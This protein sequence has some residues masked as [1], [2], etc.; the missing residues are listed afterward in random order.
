MI[1]P[2]NSSLTTI[3]QLNILVDID[4]NDHKLRDITKLFLNA[5]TDWP[6]F[7]QTNISDFTKE[8]KLYF[9]TPLT[10]EKIS[11]K[12]FDTSGGD[13]WRQEA[14]SSISEMLDLSE[15]F[16]THSDFDKTIQNILS[17]YEQEL[18]NID[19]VADLKYLTNEQGGRMTPAF[20]GYR[21]QVK[22]KFAEMQT[23]G[24]QKFLDKEMVFPGDTVRAAIKIIS[25][26]YFAHSLTEGMNFEF[27]EGPNI[28]GT[29]IIKSILNDSL[30][31]AS[32]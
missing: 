30:Q 7:N 17:Y 1:L 16:Y 3:D 9:G 31:K 21:P 32:R 12:Q 18:Q 4:K 11:N 19:F 2:N 6:T 27:R 29:G 22:F 23:S 25:V 5:A 20:S 28:I 8:L 15:Q 13:V 26:E 14:G 24:Q 10:K